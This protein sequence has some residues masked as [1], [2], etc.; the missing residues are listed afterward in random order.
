MKQG[1]GRYGDYDYDYDYYSGYDFGI[2]IHKFPLLYWFA[3]RRVT[4]LLY[5]GAGSFLL[6][7][8]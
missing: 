6:Q 3:S 5:N 2:F 8:T 1:K 7:K 4:L